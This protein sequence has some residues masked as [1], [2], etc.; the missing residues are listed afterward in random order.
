MFDMHQSCVHKAKEQLIANKRQEKTLI[1]LLTHIPYIYYKD[2][3]E[4]IIIDKCRAW[5]NPFNTNIISNFIDKDFKII[6][7]E[8]NIVDIIKSFA[9]LFAENNVEYDLNKF[10]QPNSEPLINSIMGLQT[11][12]NSNNTKN[13][14]FIEYDDLVSQPEII[15]QK[16]YDFCGWEPFEHDFNNVTVKNP[17]DDSSYGLKGFHDIRQTVSKKTNPIQELPEHIMQN[18]KMLNSL[19]GYQQ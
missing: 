9:R 8:R 13:F 5:T 18:C 3:Q 2:I 6:I 12:K 7:L 17:E 10:F 19:L 14:L 1:D 15:I 11:V 16:I 4:P